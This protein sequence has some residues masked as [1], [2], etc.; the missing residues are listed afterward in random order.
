MTAPTRHPKTG[1]YRIRIAIPPHLRDIT[2]RDHGK[3]AE[4]IETLGTKEPKETKARAPEV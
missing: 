2:Q 3:R 4:F 1:V